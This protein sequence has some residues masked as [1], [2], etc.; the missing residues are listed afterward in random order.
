MTAGNNVRG[1]DPAAPSLPDVG[2][3][4]G[5]VLLTPQKLAPPPFVVARVR[6]QRPYFRV[7]HVQDCLV[8][9]A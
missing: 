4:R 9:I 2:Q 8:L 6:L 3:A 5:H 7:D 1:I